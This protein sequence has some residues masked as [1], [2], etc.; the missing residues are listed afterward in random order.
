M[1][2]E[3]GLS[4]RIAV[5]MSARPGATTLLRNDERKAGEVW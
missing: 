3:I 5:H 1:P 4:S 2:Y